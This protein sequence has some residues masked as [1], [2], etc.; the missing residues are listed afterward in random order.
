MEYLNIVVIG[1][2]TCIGFILGLLTSYYLLRGKLS[3]VKNQWADKATIANLLRT[4]LDKGKN[5]KTKKKYYRKHKRSKS[6]GK[7]L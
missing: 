4:Q 1:I 7:K 3:D 2:V 5:G 6:S